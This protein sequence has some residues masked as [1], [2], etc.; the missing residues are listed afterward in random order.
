MKRRAAALCLLAGMF[1]PMAG[2]FSGSLD[3]LYALPAAPKDYE[4][5]QNRINEII[6]S[7]GESIAP[8]SGDKIQSIQLQ[9]LDGDGVQE[10]I[11]FFRVSGEELPLKIYIFRQVGENYETAACIEG[12][13]S[14]INSVAYEDLDGIPG[15]EI[16]VSWQMNDKVH[17]LA[18]Y[19]VNLS[20]QQV[21]ELLRTDYTDYKLMDLDQDQQ[22][23]IVTL[24]YSAEGGGRADCYNFRD[25]AVVLDSSAQLSAGVS[26][27][28]ERKA[29]FLKD[30]VPALFVTSPI[31]QENEN[32]YITDI[33]AWRSGKLENITLDP[34]TGR[35]RKENIRY[36]Y[37]AA[38]CMDI[39]GD[40][41]TEVPQPSA[42]NFKDYKTANF[43]LVQW[44]QF[45]LDGT[46]STIYT[47]YYNSQDGW[48]FVLPNDWLKKI[49]L[50]RNN[51]PGGGEQAVVFSYCPEG[52]LLAEP[53]PFLTIYKLTGTNRERRAQISGR[54]FL[55]S[56]NGGDVIFAARFEENGWPDCGLDE[57]GVIERFHVIRTDWSSG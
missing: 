37:T 48:Y 41:I 21:V 54:F 29:G 52:D 49:S 53:V 1:L 10:A 16:V 46:S 47:T 51:L 8:V 11:A 36:F 26:G 7:G 33:L 57:A 3:E 32:A 4:N 30:F 50:S 17:F 56:E 38:G 34:E 25:G 24:Q 22:T 15:R 40:S 27:V 42:L 18:A 12:A 20:Q 39:N 13:G 19:S 55:Q 44:R 31:P 35:S 45:A 9:D 6:S 5:L 2:C 28:Q 14:V 23:E 43:W